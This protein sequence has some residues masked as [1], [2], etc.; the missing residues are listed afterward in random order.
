VEHVR[1]MQLMV[2]VWIM[3]SPW[4]FLFPVIPQISE[5][6]ELL[7]AKHKQAVEKLETANASLQAV[8]LPMIESKSNQSKFGSPREMKHAKSDKSKAF[9]APSGGRMKP[10]VASRPGAVTVTTTVASVA[11]NR[12]EPVPQQPTTPT[13]NQPNVRF[14]VFH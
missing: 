7:E 4:T 3:P 11:N 8:P 6:E 1:G 5:R 14:T 9:A 10:G 2:D 13:P 12:S